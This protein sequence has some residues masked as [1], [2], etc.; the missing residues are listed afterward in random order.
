MTRAPIFTAV[1]IGSLALGIGAN[2]AIFTVVQAVLLR[3]LPYPA[4]DRLVAIRQH[5]STSGPVLATWPDYLAW[6]EQTTTLETI[7]GGWSVAYNLTGIDEP[8]RLT[9]A[10]VTASVFTTL[11][12]PPMLGG[13]FSADAAQDARVVVLSHGLWRRRFAAR[14]DVVGRR[15][16]L[17]GLSYM[18]TGVMPPAFTWPESAELWVPLVPEPGMDRGY[19]F[20]QVVGRLARGSTLAQARA[21]LAT[22]AATAASVYPATHKNRDV[23]VSSLLDATVGSTSR[24]L[25]YLPGRWPA[26]CSSPARMSPVC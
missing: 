6:Q 15:V 23:H 24:S 8:E 13:V 18:V 26:C 22:Y 11:A 21:E 12:V 20:L 4:P 3:P 5:H 1:A 19:P 25:F 7:A 9:G 10:A 17:N 16:E 2:T 14:P